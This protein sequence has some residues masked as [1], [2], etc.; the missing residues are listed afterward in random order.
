MASSRVKK[1]FKWSGIII[2]LLLVLMIVVFFLI[3]EKKP[4]GTEGPEAE[5][6]AEKVLRAINKPA[7]DS[8]TYVHWTFK[9]MHTFLWDKNRHLCKVTWDDYEV[10]LDISRI[11]GLAKKGGKVLSAEEGEKK[12]RKAWEFWCNDSFWLNAPAKIM[13]NGTSRSVVEVDGEKSLLVTYASGG[14]TPGD[15]YLWFFDEQGLPSSY[16]MWV[17]IIPFGGVEFTWEDW[18]TL[19]SGAKISTYHEGMLDLDISDL[20][21][22]QSWEEMGLGKDPFSVL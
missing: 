4:V 15:S 9:G 12:I 7:W 10:L 1:F 8:T 21:S 20:K 19:E 6:M 14:V 3:N 18:K 16:K 13:D 5:L 22:G 17:K 2:G 11:G